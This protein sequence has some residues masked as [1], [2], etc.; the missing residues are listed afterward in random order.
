MSDVPAP[1]Y[2]SA[3]KLD[4]RCVVPRHVLAAA[5]LCWLGFALVAGLVLT[6]HA[7]AFD[8]S[9][10]LYWRTGATL[11][12]RG[13][14]WLLDSIRD[15]TALGDIPVRYAL[16]GGAVIALLAAR[17]RRAAIVFT[18]TILSGWLVEAAIKLAVGRVRPML[19]PHLTHA[20]GP[21]FPSGHSFNAALVYLAMALALAR[22]SPR[23]A[24]RRALIGLALG[25]S[26][27]IALSRV[28]LG[29]HFPSDAAAGWLGGAAWAFTA[30]AL[31]DRP[32][33]DPA[34]G[35]VAAATALTPED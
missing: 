13:P 35:V 15:V 27:L 5:G 24:T 19:V 10:L 33:F 20:A 32:A 21:S 6:G 23:R 8:R 16:A 2:R 26:L 11:A 12:L 7:A 1:K 17:M 9:G 18:A 31:F 28:W 25:G 22:F 14:A 30:A 4:S 34:P 29:V 3:D